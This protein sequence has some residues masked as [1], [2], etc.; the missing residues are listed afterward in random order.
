MTDIP[1]EIRQAA[2]EALRCV[3]GELTPMAYLAA[4]AQVARALMAER[5]KALEDGWRSAHDCVSYCLANWRQD[6]RTAAERAAFGHCHELLA[7]MR[8]NSPDE[9]L[10]VE[11]ISIKEAEVEGRK[12]ALEEALGIAKSKK[13]LYRF[14][15]CDEDSG[16]WMACGTIVGAIEELAGKMKEG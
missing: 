14:P 4:E 7:E 11:W 3:D 12:K 15:Q 9:F 10:D 8:K 1:D 6:A 5:K 2:R 16:A 13:E